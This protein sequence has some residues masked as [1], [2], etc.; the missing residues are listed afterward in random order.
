MKRFV[1]SVL[2]ALMLLSLAGCG[3]SSG[4][5]ENTISLNGST[6]EV[7]G[8]GLSAKE[9]IVTVS[10]AGT[11]RISG[12]LDQGQIFV[13]TGEAAGDVI[14]VLAGAEIS[15]SSDAAI[16]VQQ[17]KNVYIQ[18]EEGTDNALVS[19]TEADFD[20]ADGSASGA[21][22]YSEDDLI[23]TGEGVLRVSGFINNGIACKDDLDIESGIITVVAANNGIRGSE[24]VEINGGNIAV[25]AKN[26]GI[27]STSADKADKGFVTVNG[28][29]ISVVTGGDGIAAETVLTVNGGELSIVTEGD[30]AAQSCKALKA[31]TG[32]DIN[33]GTLSLNSN[34]H[35][36]HSAAALN[37]SSGDIMLVV[38]DGKGIAAHEN[39]S[40]SGGSL[41]INAVSD[42]I[43]TPA[44]ILISG[45]NVNIISGEDGLRAGEANSGKGSLLVSGGD[46]YVSAAKGGI[47]V[48]DKLDISGGSLMAL[49][50]SNKA[51]TYAASQPYI[52][53]PW[54]SG[55]N[56]DTVSVS[57]SGSELASMKASNAYKSV[58]YTAAELESG[59][60]YSV[61]NVKKQENAIAG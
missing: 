50:K 52:L 46:I 30:P 61:S 17:A 58:F 10:S 37:I 29:I 21:A 44:D 6:A 7:K 55:A 9:G 13:N 2:A 4:G 14:L 51:Q 56:G 15:N 54:T 40:I 57:I 25:T 36:I 12:K 47:D 42:G 39:I 19:G 45:G 53:C 33:G 20:A 38:N 5:G 26:D 59:A 48:K 23:I 22:V 24:S 34:D 3:A 18:L 11:Y 32:L 60:E 49:G 35:G 31:K 43:E 8:V 16:Y 28:G 1:V 41:L 27:K